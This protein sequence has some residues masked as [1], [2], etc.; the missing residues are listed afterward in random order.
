MKFIHLADL[1]LGMRVSEY[2]MIGEQRHILG[3]ILRA[4][5]EEKPDAVLIAGDVY[6]KS[7]PTAEAVELFDWFLCGLAETGTEVF[8]VSGNH[9]SPERIAFASRLIDASGVHLSPVYRGSAAPVEL[10]DGFGPVYVYMLPFLRPASVRPFF[11]D[12]EIGSY[13]DAL[14]L[15]VNA[16][17]ADP[18]ARN[19]LVAHQFPEVS[20]LTSCNKSLWYIL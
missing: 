1:H 16:L 9:D 14:R 12:E 11:P 20:S 17:G 4:A 15:A 8:V 10:R 3:E 2:G 19:V 18:S 5:G 6:D 13:T 7:V